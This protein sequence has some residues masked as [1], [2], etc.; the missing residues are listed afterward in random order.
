MNKKSLRIIAIIGLAF[1][2]IFTVSFIMFLVNPNMWNGVVAFIALFSGVF[3]AGI[4]FLVMHYKK[5]LTEK[6][7]EEKDDGDEEEADVEAIEENNE[8][9]DK[10]IIESPSENVDKN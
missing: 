9:S 7:N 10:T 4:F 8:I 2:G 3:G 6:E 5:K 1:M